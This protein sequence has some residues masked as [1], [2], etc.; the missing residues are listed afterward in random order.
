MMK[1]THSFIN[2]LFPFALPI[3][4]AD[5]SVAVSMRTCANSSAKGLLLGTHYRLAVLLRVTLQDTINYD[6]VVFP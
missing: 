4:R 5:T 3:T 6:Q 1:L 2:S